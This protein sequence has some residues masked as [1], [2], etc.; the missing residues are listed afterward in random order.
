MTTIEITEDNFKEY[1][2]SK[3]PYLYIK[4]YDRIDK[5]II[6]YKVEY[7]LI[8]KVNYIDEFIVE[9][10]DNLQFLEFRF[11]KYFKIPDNLYNLT[12]L[13]IRNTVNKYTNDYNCVKCI[14]NTLI[15][16]K[17]L[18]ISDNNQIKELPKEL[19]NLEYLCI[20]KF[21]NIRIIPTTYTKL[22]ELKINVQP[23]KIKEIPKELINL[24][25]I[26][27]YYHYCDIS[28]F[29]NLKHL[30]L[31]YCSN[32]ETIPETLTNL[33]ILELC[34]CFNI[35]TLP[36]TL[37]N[38]EKLEI[39]IYSDKDY[40]LT[41]LPEE[42]TNLKFLSLSG[43]YKIKEIPKTYTKLETLKIILTTN[44]THFIP[45]E[46][47]NLKFI[48]L[49]A[50]EEDD[51]II[52]NTLINL[53]DIIS[54]QSGCSIHPPEYLEKIIKD[55]QKKNNYK[56]KYYDDEED[57]DEETEDEETEDEETEDEEDEDET[58]DDEEE[59]ETEDENEENDEEEDEEENETEEND[60]E[61]D[62]EEED[63]EEEDEN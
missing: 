28:N 41:K 30:K 13:I 43:L 44:Y 63:D 1:N 24:E 59:N 20:K 55:N 26:Y 53:I 22:K 37:T 57:E 32:I 60:E 11:C 50:F 42:Y 8:E 29:I 18:K 61:E 36:K 23:F 33:E 4:N 9:N 35:E 19:V 51:I 10:P 48:Y 38:L 54:R 5:L 40:K 58:E 56:P 21:T 14:P 2:L 16:L 52:P 47:I 3:Q 25:K 15:N 6:R 45:P 12:T 46:F 17:Y 7:I 34:N 49:G 39:L 31:Y 27:M 62:D